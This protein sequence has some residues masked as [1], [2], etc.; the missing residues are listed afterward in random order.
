MNT[1]KKT[2]ITILTVII[3]CAC[4]K[5]NVNANTGTTD[6]TATYLMAGNWKLT[7]ITVSPGVN[8]V[9]DLSSILP[10]C[11]KD[12]IFEFKAGNKFYFDQGAIKCDASLAQSDEGTWSY[13]P[14]TKTLNY[15]S[16]VL[17]PYSLTITS[18]SAKTVVGYY[19]G[20]NGGVTNTITGT[21]TLQ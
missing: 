7:S 9:T 6:K 5:E 19:M 1:I 12:N 16:P 17:H 8:G 10:E 4:S 21:F 2:A 3:T 18:S 11:E 14:A 15:S 20:V 13:D